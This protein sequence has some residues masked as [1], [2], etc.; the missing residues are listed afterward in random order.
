M[1]RAPIFMSL[2]L[3]L[4]TLA[5]ASPVQAATLDQSQ[6]LSASR[7]C[8]APHSIAS[9][10]A[11]GV[12]QTFTAGLSG[13]LSLIELELQRSAFADTTEALSVEIRA[14]DPTGA[15][16]ATATVAA[17]SIPL[18]PT[19]AWIQVPFG[20]PATLTA[21]DTYAI[22]LP[23]GPFTETTDPTYLWTIT[24]D[25]VYVSGVAWDHYDDSGVWQSY[26]FGSDRTFRTFVETVNKNPKASTFTADCYFRGSV[27]VE[28]IFFADDNPNGGSTGAFRVI[29]SNEVFIVY[30]FGTDM[31]PDDRCFFVWN[32]GAE[33]K[34]PWNTGFEA[35]VFVAPNILPAN[36]VRQRAFPIALDEVA[37]Q[38]TLD[39][40]VGMTD[41][42][43]C[44][45]EPMPPSSHTVWY[46][47]TAPADGTYEVNTIGSEYDTTLF[48]L[49]PDGAVV[50]CDDDIVLTV[51]Q[52]SQ[53]TFEASAGTTY[54]IMVGSYD[55]SR[56]GG[57][58]LTVVSVPLGTLDQSAEGSDGYAFYQPQGYPTAGV[59]GA[60]QTFT[61]G[62]SG[63]LTQ[64]D[65]RL[66]RASWTTEAISIEIH[67]TEPGGALLA[68]SNPV[69]AAEVP[70]EPT[71]DWVAFTF[72]APAS[73]TPGQMY[74]IVLPPDIVTDDI[75]PTYLWA[76][77]GADVYAD[78]VTWD[79]YV[80][81]PTW[82][83]YVF[84]DDRTF[85]T[86]VTEANGS[87]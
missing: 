28:A 82:H 24:F 3:I 7:S 86:Y 73:V 58:V 74:A 26:F 41:P 57:L 31:Q 29:H 1:K 20:S 67:A 5:F 84:G 37:T 23:P 32:G 77:T 38:N 43:E 68:V 87:P 19:F 71:F 35:L 10:C 22:V 15:V 13:Q 2:L 54:L 79:Q 36:D 8:Y 80:G 39:A 48:V 40:R 62:L 18:E 16:L 6:E 52:D 12:A 64:V 55:G 9:R 81:D 61:A 14:G 50:A 34:P 66:A 65:L 42:Q 27:D 44:S 85:R 63:L 72:A 76:G 70:L 47:F 30:T 53:L 45:A 60:A 69:L 59:K 11:T 33:P 56:G 25:D 75:D 83:P 4:S 17:A 46:A 51:D 49:D 78:G 21:G